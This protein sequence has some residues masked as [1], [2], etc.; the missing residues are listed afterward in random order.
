MYINCVV[1]SIKKTKKEVHLRNTCC[2]KTTLEYVPRLGCQ[3]G[4]KILLNRPGY[5]ILKVPLQDWWLSDLFF[6]DIYSALL[7]VF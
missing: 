1:K 5:E 2:I 6:G 3:V 4:A 7:L